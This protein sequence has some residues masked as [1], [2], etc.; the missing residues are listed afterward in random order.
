MAGEVVEDEFEF[1]ERAVEGG[2]LDLFFCLR[3][4]W[5]TFW[6]VAARLCAVNCWRL[7]FAISSSGKV[8]R[9]K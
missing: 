3:T 4:F 8:L 9:K 6:E 2:I 7:N 5:I 1:D